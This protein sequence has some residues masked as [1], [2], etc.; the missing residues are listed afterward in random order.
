MKSLQCDAC[1][2]RAQGNTFEEWFKAMQVHYANDHRDLM[3]AMKQRSKEDG[4][5]WMVAAKA[6]FDAE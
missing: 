4:A 1:A 3:D 6:R 5:R 2:F